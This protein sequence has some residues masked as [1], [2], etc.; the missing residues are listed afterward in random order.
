MENLV[1]YMP[2]LFSMFYILYLQMN[3]LHPLQ[4]GMITLI[5]IL[6]KMNLM[7]LRRKKQWRYWRDSN[8]LHVQTV[9]FTMC[10]NMLWTT[11]KLVNKQF[12]ATL[13]YICA[14]LLAICEAVRLINMSLM[15][16][17]AVRDSKAFIMGE[18]YTTKI[19]KSMH[20]HTIK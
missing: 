8:S 19:H 3:Y 10:I 18:I 1:W 5:L 14:T 20:N 15:L 2:L 12:H 17:Q 6:S 16:K 9:K 13:L 11:V 7:N 4:M